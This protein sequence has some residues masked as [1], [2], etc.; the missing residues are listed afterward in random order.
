MA[1]QRIIA[2]PVALPWNIRLAVAV[3]GP[4]VLSLDIWNDGTAHR[5]VCELHLGCNVMRPLFLLIKPAFCWLSHVVLVALDGVLR[6]EMPCVDR[7]GACVLLFLKLCG[8]GH[9]VNGSIAYANA[10]L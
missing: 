9:L 5:D 3:P 7:S 2:E 1:L 10:K 8:A 6:V 4:L